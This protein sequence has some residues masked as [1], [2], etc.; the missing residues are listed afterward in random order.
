MVNKRYMRKRDTC[1]GNEARIY[2]LLIKKPPGM[3]SAGGASS[4]CEQCTN[5]LSKAVI[6]KEEEGEKQKTTNM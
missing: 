1:V 5:K 4:M 6:G 2:K 3:M